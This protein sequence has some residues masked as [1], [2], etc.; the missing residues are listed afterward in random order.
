MSRRVAHQP[1]LLDLIPRPKTDSLVDEL[2]E[3]PGEEFIQRIRDELHG[4]LARARATTKGFP[5]R[6]LTETYVIELRVNSM[7]RWLP[8]T[9]A[10]ELRRVFSAEMDRLYEAADLERPEV[11]G[12]DF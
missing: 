4:Y 6:D 3:H 1:D 11:G 5:W 2:D 9:E 12:L 8:G 10:A 7:S